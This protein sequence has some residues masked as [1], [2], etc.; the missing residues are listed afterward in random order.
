MKK[1]KWMILPAVAVV[2][3]AA[4]AVAVFLTRPTALSLAINGTDVE[5]EEYLRVMNNEI[6][7][8]TQQFTTEFG[9]KIDQEFWEKDFNGKVPSRVLADNTIEKLKSLRAVYEL[10]K[11][12]GY[13][14]SAGYRD[15]LT[16]FEKENKSRQ[17]KVEKGET[18]YGLSEFTL[19]L[20]IEYEMDAIQKAYCGDLNNEGMQLTD[21]EIEAYYEEKKASLFTKD[22]DVEYSYLKIDTLNEGLSEAQIKE[23]R[24]ELEAL[25][26]QIG[27]DT[28]MDS[29][30]TGN[31]LLFPYYH[32]QK[33]LSAESGSYSKVMGDVMELGAALKKG[34]N[35]QVLEVNGTL[36]LIQCNDRVE[37]DYRPLEEVKAN[38]EKNLREQ[39]YDELVAQRAKNAVVSGD[40]ERVYTF[41]KENIKK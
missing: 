15:L 21:A 33:I 28:S 35:T 4:V 20:F 16:R 37:Y 6:Y 26:K 22:D 19:D 3:V 32:S 1:K 9:A 10:A 31:E 30:I 34:E 2:V 36:L 18:V 11:E 8:V 25:Y 27:P 24:Q 12:K 5:Q 13:V 14:D 7:G 41:T 23:L 39:H 40:L 29:L 38:I 17:E